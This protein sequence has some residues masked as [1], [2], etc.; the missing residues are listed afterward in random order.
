MNRHDRGFHFRHW[1][2]KTGQYAKS[3]PDFRKKFFFF[4]TI[5]N[6]RSLILVMWEH[7]SR[8]ITFQNPEI[9]T[10]IIETIDFLL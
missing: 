1:A 9:S 4:G 5:C 6:L 3:Y 7:G 8:Q 10:I 2:S